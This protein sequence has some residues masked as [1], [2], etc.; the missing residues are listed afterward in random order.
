M[1]IISNPFNVKIA[2]DPVFL[3]NITPN[4]SSLI[5]I[6]IMILLAIPV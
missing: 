3:K 4:I 2:K 1:N 6:I 5:L